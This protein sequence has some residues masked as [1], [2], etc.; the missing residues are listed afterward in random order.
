[1]KTKS[2]F[3]PVPKLAYFYIKHYLYSHCELYLYYS[4]L[5]SK[6]I[7]C[8]HHVLSWTRVGLI[9]ETLKSSLN[10]VV[11]HFNSVTN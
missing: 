7:M 4:V 10:L 6:F 3:S 11:K 1:M 9:F 8:A 5:K 2:S